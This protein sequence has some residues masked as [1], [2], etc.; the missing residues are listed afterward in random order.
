MTKTGIKPKVYRTAVAASHQ[1]I[2]SVGGG[3]VA[4]GLA[5][6]IMAVNR[7]TQVYELL[8]AHPGED[9]FSIYT[10]N[11]AGRILLDFPNATTKHSVQLQHSLTELL[12][13]G[14]IKIKSIEEAA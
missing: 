14:T 2:A 10:S 5:A 11:T 13:V 7:V 6:T 4:G 9:H 12:G 1:Y 8:Q 3:T